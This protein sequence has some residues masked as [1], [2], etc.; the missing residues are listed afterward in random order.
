MSSIAANTRKRS[1]SPSSS[2]AAGSTA[3]RSKRGGAAAKG[4]AEGDVAEDL[5]FEDPY[6]DEWGSSSDDEEG[7]ADMATRRIRFSRPQNLANNFGLNLQAHAR[8]G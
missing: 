2:S 3:G 5:V 7:G 8:L 4:A 1:S 6:E